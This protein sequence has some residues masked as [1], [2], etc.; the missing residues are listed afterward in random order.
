MGTHPLVLQLAMEGL[1]RKLESIPEFFMPAE[2]KTALLDDLRELEA[3]LR[4]FGRDPEV[5]AMAARDFERRLRERYP[6][7]PS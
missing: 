6:D 2:D 4:E 5:Q 1:E 7:P 3:L